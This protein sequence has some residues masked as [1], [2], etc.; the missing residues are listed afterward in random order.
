ML[1]T[2]APVV[3][4]VPHDSYRLLHNVYDS[5]P[6][7]LRQANDARRSAVEEVERLLQH[8]EDLKRLPALREEYSQKQ[9]ARASGATCPG[10]AAASCCVS[11][12]GCLWAA[13]LSMIM[14]LRSSSLL[15][16]P[17][18]LPA[19]IGTQANK[20]QLS[21]TVSSQTENI[22]TGLELVAK[23]KQTLLNLQRSFRVRS[24]VR[25]VM[26]PARRVVSRRSEICSISVLGRLLSVLVS[27]IIVP[28]RPAPNPAQQISPMSVPAEPAPSPQ[29]IDAL[30]TECSSLIEN[31]EKIQ[32]LSMVHYNLGKTLA[33]VENIAALPAEAAEAEHMLK[34]D[35]QLIQATLDQPG[36]V[37]DPAAQTTC[38]GPWFA[39]SPEC[40]GGHSDAT[41]PGLLDPSLDKLRPSS[42]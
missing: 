20:A 21:A 31:H 41:S 28:C 6:R 1:V 23:S 37:H 27:T 2:P 40:P 17:A 3:T 39:F 35:Y 11:P 33:D 7:R 25:A 30:C 34:D 9:Q 10:A 36:D 5:V 42:S 24:D 32:L 15:C 12:M 22:R 14:H 4:A 19:I 38:C 16:A 13:G 18:N 26:R 29:E 8:P